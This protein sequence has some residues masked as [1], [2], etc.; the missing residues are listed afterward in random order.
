MAL[1]TLPAPSRGCFLVG[2]AG[3]LQF[4]NAVTSGDEHVAEF[5]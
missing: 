4:L 1:T 5:G 2:F 3:G